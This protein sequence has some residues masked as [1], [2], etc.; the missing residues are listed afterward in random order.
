M[1]DFSEYLAVDDVYFYSGQSA[2]ELHNQWPRLWAKLNREAVEEN[3]KLD[4]VVFWMRAAYAG[5]N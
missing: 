3:G 5:K 4:D 1:A 2:Y